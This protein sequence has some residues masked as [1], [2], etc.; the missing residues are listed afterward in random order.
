MDTQQLMPSIDVL[1]DFGN[2]QTTIHDDESG[3]STRAIA[4]YFEEAAAKS[5]A[6]QLQAEGNQEKHFAGLLDGAFQAA[7]RIVLAAWERSHN[8]PLQH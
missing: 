2:L 4:A 3:A 7:Q 6:M 8:A 1:A 5:R